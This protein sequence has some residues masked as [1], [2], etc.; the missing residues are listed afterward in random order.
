MRH[1]ADM[2]TNISRIAFAV[3][4]TYG[5]VWSIG[6]YLCKNHDAIVA[7]RGTVE[8]LCMVAYNGSFSPSKNR[9]ADVYRSI[10]PSLPLLTSPS[11]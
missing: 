11:Y 8:Y 2:L 9:D 1:V 5:V 4:G 6:D 3:L 10:S 7:S